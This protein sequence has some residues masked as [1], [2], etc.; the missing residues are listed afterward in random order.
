MA[1]VKI[2]PRRDTA[3]N[4]TSV[5]PTL[6]AGEFARE[7][8]SGRFKFGDD[9][10]PWSALGYWKLPWIDITG[11]PTTLA[12][13]GITDALPA[14]A[15]GAANG[16]AS[17]G[18]DSKV[19][20]GQLPAL[21]ITDVYVVNSQAAQV[22]L[23]AEE[24]DVAVR[25][26][27]KK[28]YIHNG[29]TSGTIADWQ[30]LLTPTDQ[31]ISVNGKAGTVVLAAGDIGITP[32]GNVQ[33]TTVQ[34]AIAELDAE[35]QKAG[36][37]VSPSAS[38]TLELTDAEQTIYYLGA[39]VLTMTIPLASAVAFPLNTEIRFVNLTGQNYVI[40]RTAGVSLFSFGKGNADV[41]IA[42]NGTASLRKVAANVW[43]ISGSG[44]S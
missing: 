17:L 26:D 6:A 31:V 4:W 43:A 42:N 29:G 28:S 44:L 1:I 12:G 36:G 5:N 37:I 25:T 7:T 18:A 20:V 35:K 19:P 38:R 32:A 22:A 23:V 2:R 11:K 8:D 10:T 30:E 15:R 9:V 21:A 33:A 27:Q 16:V 24:G 34:A 14:S 3:T 39:G 40:A 13:Y 41:T